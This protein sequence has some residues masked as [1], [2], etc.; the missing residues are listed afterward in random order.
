MPFNY[1]HALLALEAEAA[2]GPAVTAL[3][4]TCREAYRAGAM[5]P[6]PYFADDMPKPL[7]QQSRAA[8]A[9]KLHALDARRLFGTFLPL[10]DSAV[11][12]AYALGL[13]CHFTLDTSAHAFIF[14]RFPG[15][16]HTPAEMHMDLPMTDRYP[17]T[18][19]SRRPPAFFRLD[20]AA[21]SEIDALHAAAAKALFSENCR[22]AFRRSYRKWV[23]FVNRFS[24]DPHGR[25]LRLFQK[26]ERRPGAVTGW[27]VTRDP[28]D[29]ERDLMN[30]LHK[31]WAAPWAT[32][33]LRTESFPEL[34]EAALKETPALLNAAAAGF[35]TGDFSEAL[36]LAGRRCMNGSP[37]LSE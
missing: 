23:C 8:L 19:F 24:F 31:P 34:F 17:Q 16:L 5:G 29:K 36:R 28:A 3:T 25:K 18:A 1:A 9:G 27:L 15:K 4:E 10:A 6:D 14:A 20:R 2:A 13:I 33:R 21:L 30:L 7:F 37:L 35:E 22:G 11:K 32:G 12:R 26:L